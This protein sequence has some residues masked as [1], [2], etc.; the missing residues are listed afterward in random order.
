MA[1]P[2]VRDS[3]RHINPLESS[4]RVANRIISQRV[5]GDFAEHASLAKL[6]D[7]VAA[8]LDCARL[9]RER[10]STVRHAIIAKNITTEIVLARQQL[11]FPQ[12]VERAIIRALYE[13]V[14]D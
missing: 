1:V 3:A 13:A 8:A 5:V 10:D 6:A 14:A 12:M 9:R 11:G 2:A 4:I 7:D